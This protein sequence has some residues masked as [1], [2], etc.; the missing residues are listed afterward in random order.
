MSVKK[1]K[2]KELTVG[3]YVIH[4]NCAKKR[5]VHKRSNAHSPLR[6]IAVYWPF[7]IFEWSQK[8]Q[9]PALAI[10]PEG[11][12]MMQAGSVTKQRIVLNVKGH[13]FIEV[14]EEFAEQLTIA[15]TSEPDWLHEKD[16]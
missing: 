14:S 13:K 3:M 5:K 9:M 12:A 1:L 7:A 2:A 16:K 6:V 8:N 4:G 11:P 15:N 10:G